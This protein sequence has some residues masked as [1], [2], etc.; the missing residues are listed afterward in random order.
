MRL[1]ADGA[2][3][4]HHD[5]GDPRARGRSPSSAVAELPA[6]RAPA[7]R[8]PGASARAWWSTSRSRTRPSEPGYD[9]G[10]AVAAL[11][12]VAID[13]AGLDRPGDRV[14]LPGQHAASRAGGR[15]PPRARA[16]C[17]PSS[18]IPRPGSPWRST[19]G[20]RAVHPFVSSVTPD[21]VERAHAAGLA[22][23][24]WTVNAP[25]DLRAMVALGVDTVITDRLRRGPVHRRP[26][27]GLSRPAAAVGGPA[28]PQWPLKGAGD[29]AEWREAARF[30]KDARP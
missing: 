10:E 12:A 30:V 23:N 29:R 22:V 13:E 1:T 25:A 8:R 4:V 9:P 2:L 5:R 3:A 28:G 24:V 27:A 26:R 15:R 7:G 18:P 6:A 20:W 17:G 14:V 21:L 19:A 11:T 16:R